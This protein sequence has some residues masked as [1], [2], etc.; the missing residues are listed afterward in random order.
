VAYADEAIILENSALGYRV[1]YKLEDFEIN[2]ETRI[3][4]F[5][6][7]P[8]FEDLRDRRNKNAERWKLNRQKAYYGSM[9]HFMRSIYNNR[10]L[11]EEFE[12][13][14]ITRK[15]NTE[16]ERVR[17]IYNTTGVE[18]LPNDSVVYYRQVL[19]RNDQ[20]E[21]VGVARLTAD[22]LIVRVNGPNK[23][24]Y[25]PDQLV[26][27]YLKKFDEHNYS[28]RMFSLNTP[29]SR[30]SYITLPNDRPFEIDVN[31]NYPPTELLSQGYWAWSEKMANYLPL[32]Y[33]P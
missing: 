32:D 19:S 5:Y 12:V 31:G 18:G 25:F 8:F 24:V 6:G 1:S 26:I 16:K 13:R 10:V 3:S 33:E 20:V 17:N 4:V 15:I 29:S 22:S 11:E 30:R 2:F 21:S 27:T 14:R 23:I 28:A 7:F 9:L